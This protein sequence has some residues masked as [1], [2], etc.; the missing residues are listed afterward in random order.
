MK[1]NVFLIVGCQRSGTTLMRLLLECHSHVECYDESVA[2]EIMAGRRDVPPSMARLTGLKVPC[3]TEQLTDA[4]LWDPR[5]LPRMPNHYAGEK[6]LFLVRDARAVAASMRRLQL[7][8]RSWID[9][10]L[11]PTIRQKRA[12]T[13]SFQ[14]MYRDLFDRLDGGHFP[15]VSYAAFCWRYKNDALLRYLYRGLPIML[16]QYEDLVV[17]PEERLRQVCAF[18]GVSW[19][20][21]LLRHYAYRHDELDDSGLAIG[22]TDPRQPITDSRI[23]SWRSYLR[24]AEVMEIVQVAGGCQ[25]WLY[26]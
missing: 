12:T 21:A 5:L 1:S 14:D 16:V 26:E 18:L 22:G 4:E 15:E 20:D 17:R 3:I 23:A 19:E 7:S 8:G 11:K 10:C 2:Y 24:P 25:R 9:S 13:P 6:V